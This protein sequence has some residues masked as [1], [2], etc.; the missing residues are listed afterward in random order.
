[1]NIKKFLT[2]IIDTNGNEFKTINEAYDANALITHYMLNKLKNIYLHESSY[3][4]NGGIEEMFLI[5]CDKIVSITVKEIRG[6]ED[7]KV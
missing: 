4:N 1:M 7:G 2:T 6:E 3:Y 5:R